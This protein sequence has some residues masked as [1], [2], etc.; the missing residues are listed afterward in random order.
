MMK[1]LNIFFATLGVLFFV[2]IIGGVSVYI[3]SS[4][5]GSKLPST[6]SVPGAQN[7]TAATTETGSAAVSADTHPLLSETQ[8]KALKTFGIDPATLPTSISPAQEQCFIEKLGAEKVAVI[9]N[10]AAP[11]ATDLFMARDCIQ[12]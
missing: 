10:G 1:F 12:I 2:L 8:E 7:E 4:M 11:S 5:T 9:K 6:I 3:F